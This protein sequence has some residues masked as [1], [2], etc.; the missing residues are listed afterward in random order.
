MQIGN[1]EFPYPVFNNSQNMSSYKTSSFA[2]DYEIEEE[3][4]KLIFKDVEIVTNSSDLK[5]LLEIGKAKACLV[6]DCSSTVYKEIFEIGLEAKNIEIKKANLNGTFEVSAF[7][8]SAE[9]IDGFVSE[10]LLDEY[11]GFKF[12]IEENCI[13]AIDDGYKQKVEYEDFE[14]KK[15][16]S[17]F[18][19][20]KN[21]DEEEKVMKVVL[22]EKKIKITI[23][24]NEFN[25]YD[26]I[27]G[28]D[29]FNN[30]FF[31]IIVIPA[32][33]YALNEIKNDMEKNEKDIED[34]VYEYSW[35]ESIRKSYQKNSEKEL[36]REVFIQSNP[37]ELS[38]ELVNN[39]ST[40]AISDFFDLVARMK[41]GEEDE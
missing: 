27:K 14:D 38:Q 29:N 40:L 5:H 8:Y 7:V 28:N 37:F 30:I 2:F 25:N 32:L 3:G 26:T 39:C 34:I 16:S 12:N 41:E 33:T 17:I 31:S 21:M 35:F 6:I 36:S 13:I 15:V 24:E 11:Y 19:I 23:P 20:V 4:D 1:K 18:S 10:D 22:D 9:N